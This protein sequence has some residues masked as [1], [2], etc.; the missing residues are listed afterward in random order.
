MEAGS[1]PVQI[2]FLCNGIEQGLDNFLF[3]R[4]SESTPLGSPFFIL[5]AQYNCKERSIEGR[6]ALFFTDCCSEYWSEQDKRLYW[7]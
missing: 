7:T 4:L 6:N 2:W 3:P 5:W 1:G